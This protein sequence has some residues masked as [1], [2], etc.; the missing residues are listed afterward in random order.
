[1]PQNFTAGEIKTN[2][3]AE[4]YAML[5]PL[6]AQDF[7]SLKDATELHQILNLTNRQQVLAFE[8]L[9]ATFNAHAHPYITESGP[10][11]TAPTLSPSASIARPITILPSNKQAISIVEPPTPEGPA[12]KT[13]I[14]I[15][16]PPFGL[17]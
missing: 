11:I 12:R 13:G 7:F 6:I 10:S 4:L 8:S 1:M 2:Q 16:I 3:I 17:E 14:S 9:K 15:V 5:Y